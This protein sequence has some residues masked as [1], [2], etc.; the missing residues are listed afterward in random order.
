MTTDQTLDAEG[1][2]TLT[3]DNSR[4]LS[5]RLP[6]SVAD[7]IDRRSEEVER[8]PGWYLRN[9][10]LVALETLHNSEAANAAA[11]AGVQVPEQPL[12]HEWSVADEAGM[13]GHSYEIAVGFLLPPVAV[14][15]WTAY[16]IRDAFSALAFKYGA[17]GVCTRTISLCGMRMDQRQDGHNPVA[18]ENSPQV[19]GAVS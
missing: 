7:E 2:P 13:G 19:G 1:G 12:A 17:R 3:T 5:V 14:P 15:D 18:V 4:V 16:D 10:I 9:M 11:Q 8:S 6:N